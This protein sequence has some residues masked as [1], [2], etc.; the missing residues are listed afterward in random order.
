MAPAQ[1]VKQYSQQLLRR[2]R[3]KFVTFSREVLALAPQFAP[4][5]QSI[6]LLFVGQFPGRQPSQ[7]GQGPLAVSFSSRV[8]SGSQAPQPS[9]APSHSRRGRRKNRLVLQQPLEIPCQQPFKCRVGFAHASMLEK[10]RLPRQSF[11]FATLACRSDTLLAMNQS[12]LLEKAI[13]IAV[14]AHRGQTDRYGA[15]YILHPLR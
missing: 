5:C 3:F 8:K 1:F 7:S 2:V 10:M 13:G 9:F 14:N 11:E 12:E 6:D 15:P 4:Q